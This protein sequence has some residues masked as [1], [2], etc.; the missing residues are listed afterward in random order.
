MTAQSHQ[1]PDE[2][3][4]FVSRWL[5][6]AMLGPDDTNRVRTNSDDRGDDRALAMRSN[7]LI[8][9]NCTKEVA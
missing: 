1:N 8:D 4:W 6:S 7:R 5:V 3:V 2:F 9:V